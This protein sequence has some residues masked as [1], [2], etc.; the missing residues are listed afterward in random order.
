M[1]EAWLERQTIDGERDFVAEQYKAAD[2]TPEIRDLL[3]HEVLRNYV[4][5]RV[6]RD[7]AKRIGMAKLAAH[8]DAL[9]LPHAVPTRIGDFGEILAGLGL[10]KLQR[11]T[12]PI[13]KLRYKTG[14]NALLQLIDIVAFKFVDGANAAIVAVVEVK[15]STTRPDA[16]LG[17]E[18]VR[19]LRDDLE[20]RLPLSL[21]FIDCRLI[22]A[23]HEWLAG[24]IEEVLAAEATA[25]N[26]EERVVLVVDAAHWDDALLERIQ[27]DGLASE[28]LTATIYVIGDLRDLIDK[29]YEAAAEAHGVSV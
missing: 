23:G 29:T 21:H 1:L 3:A 26:V 9:V 5:L 17:S 18:A 25:R 13:L 15:T 27:Q 7:R 2:L 19:Q 28:K 8:I 22:E 11:Y 12:L 4:E 10:R 6:L 14:P 16:D 24:K 20:E